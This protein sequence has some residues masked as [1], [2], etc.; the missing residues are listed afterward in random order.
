MNVKEVRYTDK[1]ELDFE[2]ISIL[3]TN[4]QFGYLGVISSAIILYFVMSHYSSSGLANLWLLITVIANIPR[5]IISI[6]FAKGIK[7]QLINQNNIRSWERYM[8]GGSAIAYLAFVSVIFFPYDESAAVAVALC[9]FTFMI[10]ATGGVLVLSTSLP[11]IVLFITVII[12]AIVCRFLM[13]EDSLFVII[14]IIFI[15]GYPQLLKLIVGQHRI[16]VENIALRIS[17]SKFALIDP[18]TNLANR[19]ML[20]S[21]MEKLL[22]T[23]QRTGE[24]YCLIML[25]VDHF[26]QYNDHKGH[27]AGDELLLKV[28]DALRTCSR[29]EDLVVRYGGEEFLIVLPRT[30][31]ASAEL[32]ARRICTTVKLETDI[33]ISAGLAEYSEGINFEQL[34]DKADKALY[35]AKNNG[36]DQ[37]VLA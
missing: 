26:K 27:S 9:A 21:Y 36:R 5:V 13:M 3:F 24:P 31:L 29:A 10:V 22:P 6:R 16:L 12:G 30:Q 7:A 4:I 20:Y 35:V 17:H 33:T 34:L 8:F 25:D 2:R 28:A 18:L 1:Q 15:F 11:A 19:R 14:A 32:I 37:Y 23:T